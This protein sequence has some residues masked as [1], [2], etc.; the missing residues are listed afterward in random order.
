MP[1]V[2]LGEYAHEGA[3]LYAELGLNEH[4]NCFLV[5]AGGQL[6]SFFVE[7]LD[8]LCL[9]DCFLELEHVFHLSLYFGEDLLVVQLHY[10]SHPL[11]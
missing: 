8:E 11:L 3:E 5:L 6:D 9:G 7:L 10:A 1:E 2:Q 4:S